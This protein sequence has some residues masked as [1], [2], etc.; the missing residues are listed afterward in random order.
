[1]VL[2]I[3]L[4]TKSSNVFKCRISFLSKVNALKLVFDIKGETLLMIYES[5][6]TPIQDDVGLQSHP[7]EPIVLGASRDSS[8]LMRFAPSS[9]MA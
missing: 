2:I 4:L 6:I 7:L 8:F 5:N 1:M 3:V 9:Q